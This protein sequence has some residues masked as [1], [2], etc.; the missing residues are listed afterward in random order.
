MIDSAIQS[1]LLPFLSGWGWP[2]GVAYPG[3]AGY[4]YVGYE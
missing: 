1:P 3:G 2:G 4:G